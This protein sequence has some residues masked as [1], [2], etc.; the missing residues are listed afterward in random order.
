MFDLD[1]LDANV[2][3]R[4]FI[5]GAWRSPQSPS[6]VPLVSPATDQVV[7]EL[8]AGND[9]D[10][11][12]AL[13]AA[14]RAFDSGPWPTSVAAERADAIDRLADAL[15]LRTDTL[16]QLWTAQVAAPVGLTSR[17]VGEG[18]A[19]LRYFAGLA[20]HFD[21]EELR[22][23][24]GGAARIRREPAGAA[25][26][27]IPWNAAFPILCNKLGAALAA[28]CT[29]IIKP[30]PASPLEALLV[31]Q[32]ADEAELPPGVVNV[33]TAGD[34]ESARLVA[35]PLVD[36]ISFTGSLATGRA[37]AAACAPNLTRLTLELGGKNAAIIMDDADLDV[38]LDALM[39]FT[40]P[41]S[42]QFCFAQSR[43]L[44]ARAR[45]AELIGKLDERIAAL[46]VG[47]PWDPATQIGPVLNNR[48][49]EHILG[50]VDDS[51][52]RGAA[53]VRGGRRAPGFGA[54]HYIEPTLVD[55][56]RPDMPIARQEI[57]GP[58]VTVETFDDVE[59][60]ID[61]ANAPGY[62]LSGSVY[63]RDV[64][65]A[66]AVA[67]GIRSGQVGINGL[68]L[69]P[70]VPFGGYGLSGLGREGGPEGLAA[71][72]ETK[73][74]L[75]P[76]AVKASGHVAI[77]G[78]DYIRAML[79][80]S[81]AQPP[82][83][84]FL[85]IRCEAVDA[86]VVTASLPHDF[87]IENAEGLLHGGATAAL[88]DATMG[89]AAHSVQ[90]AGCGVVTLDLTTSFLKPVRPEQ[91]PIAARA[92]VLS[93]GRISIYVEAEV[94]DR[95]NRLVAHAVAN[96]RSTGRAVTPGEIMAE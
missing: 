46:R 61:M 52:V 49:V 34:R 96:F 1:K 69:A 8:P 16:A 5:D 14:R 17:L 85:S 29:T 30:S 13:T 39:P 78:L 28:G 11:D 93:Q 68:A 74:L 84:D 18:I 19:R 79:D 48:Q 36:K 73:A 75:L 86:G 94:R 12:R 15:A 56:V 32:C 45:H 3:E 42:G 44:V 47:D 51:R 72:L 60:A 23:T 63:S 22:R 92:R 4:F 21:F 2:R 62:G 91:M 37:I 55:A 81:V 66:S 50:L 95:E 71:F 27:I 7:A 6:R 40:M 35:S 82:L 88:L 89:A 41:F 59:Q 90:P 80:G 26:L 87:R 20:R 25:L 70:S 64:K 77:A 10:I 31:A 24:A 57:F 83:A 38:A 53:I 76:A 65:A 58:V 33:V 54:G 43:V 9:E 67:C